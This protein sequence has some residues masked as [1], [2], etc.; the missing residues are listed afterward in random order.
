[1]GV[2]FLVK[3]V[4]LRSADGTVPVSGPEFRGLSSLHVCAIATM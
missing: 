1:M 3:P 2:I 4:P